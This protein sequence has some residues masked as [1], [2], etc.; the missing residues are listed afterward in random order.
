MEQ[1]INNAS[2][3]QF[4]AYP[5]YELEEMANHLAFKIFECRARFRRLPRSERLLHICA[6]NETIY[7]IRRRNEQ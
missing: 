3:A 4:D 5:Q 1:Y 6:Y 2:R 7:E